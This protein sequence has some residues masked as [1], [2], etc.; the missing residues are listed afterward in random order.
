MAHELITPCGQEEELNPPVTAATDVWA[1]AMTVIEVCN[2]L[3][4]LVMRKSNTSS[5][6]RSSPAISPSLTLSEISM[7]SHM[8]NKVVVPSG[9]NIHRSRTKFGPSWKSAGP[10]KPISVHQWKHF[11]K[12]LR[13]FRR[14]NPACRC[15]YIH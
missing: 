3:S 9:M 15:S 4:I 2:Y 12:F 14:H 10:L 1:F 7:S 8:C 13:C 6:S 11:P 5:T